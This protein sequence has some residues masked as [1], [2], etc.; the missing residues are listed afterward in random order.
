MHCFEVGEAFVLQ[1][2]VKKSKFIFNTVVSSIHKR[3]E[4]HPL[5]M[6]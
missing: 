1:P 5:K 6:T 3:A 2:F 4:A